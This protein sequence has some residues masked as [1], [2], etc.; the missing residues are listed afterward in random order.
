MNASIYTT[1][2]KWLNHRNGEQVSGCHELRRRRGRWEV[3][4]RDPCGDGNVLYLDSTTVRFLALMSYYSFGTC[5]HWENLGE[6]GTWISVGFLQLHANLQ[7][8]EKKSS[9]KRKVYL[10][11]WKTLLRQ[12]TSE[13]VGC[14]WE[15][16][17]Y[18]KSLVLTTVLWLCKRLPLFLENMEILHI[19]LKR[20]DKYTYTYIH[21]Y[22]H[23]HTFKNFSLK[24]FRKIIGR[25]D[26]SKANVAKWFKKKNL[27]NER[28][29]HYL[30]C[31]T[32]VGLCQNPT[33]NH[34]KYVQSVYNYLKIQNLI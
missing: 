16:S 31:V 8:T 28:Y 26:D 4:I 33:K 14:I 5:Y 6:G 2:L 1:F 11:L 9:M 17:I 25:R 18:I 15:N 23:I 29:S 10:L 12:L 24:R 34:F 7:L 13:N 3:A 30:R 21:P 27:W 19:E 20:H 32:G 22:T